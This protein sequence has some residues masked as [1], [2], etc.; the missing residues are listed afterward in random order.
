MVN[1]F[2]EFTREARFK[3]F[4]DIE[5]SKISHSEHVKIFKALEH[6]DAELCSK[7]MQ[8]HLIH[9]GRLWQSVLE[10]DQDQS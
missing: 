8:D 2:Y 3:Y 10:G 6:G 1:W 4:A 9:A 5:R 7:L